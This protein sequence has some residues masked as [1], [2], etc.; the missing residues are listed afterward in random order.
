MMFLWGRILL[1]NE[2]VTLE[3]DES[4]QYYVKQSD[5]YKVEEIVWKGGLIEIYILQNQSVGQY[6]WIL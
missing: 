3:I 4:Q 1:R 5:A 2:N 6:W